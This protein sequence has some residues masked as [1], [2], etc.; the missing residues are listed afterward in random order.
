MAAT[1]LKS[2]PK[3]PADLSAELKNLWK[4]SCWRLIN[5][6]DGMFRSDVAMVE[7]YVRL[8]GRW[9]Q[10]Q[11]EAD[12]APMYNE[13]GKVSEIFRI[14][15]E[16]SA[17]VKGAFRSLENTA[18]ERSRAARIAQSND[19]G[20]QAGVRQK[21]ARQGVKSNGPKPPSSISWLDDARKKA[22]SSD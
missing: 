14:E 12:N 2:V 9:K 1:K 13:K 4:D 10:V 21:P 18:N 11:S 19:S 20:G 6:D 8:F 5:A 16:L 7:S 15:S 22:V 3:P 17:K